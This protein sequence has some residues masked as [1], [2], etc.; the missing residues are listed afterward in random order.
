MVGLSWLVKHKP[1]IDWSSGSIAGWSPF[2]LANCLKSAPQ[3]LNSS[4]PSSPCNID[5]SSVPMPYWG[6]KEVF[7]KARATSLPLHQPYDCTIKLHPGT[8][9]PRGCLYSLSGPETV[10]GESI[11]HQG[12]EVQVSSFDC[13]ISGLRCG[14]RVHPDGSQQG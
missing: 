3:V 14:C 7:N 4:V 5:V 2:C 6:L 1:H 12:R 10:V 9:P 13:V 8:T 11:V